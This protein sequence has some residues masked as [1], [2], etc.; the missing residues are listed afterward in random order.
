MTSVDAIADRLRR[1]GWSV[2]QAQDAAGWRVTAT[3]PRTLIEATAPTQL[4]AWRRAVEQAAAA[5]MFG[6]TEPL[7]RDAPA[8]AVVPRVSR[9]P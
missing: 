4:E 8:V 9:A 2:A 3:R 7:R 1:S 5:G 6:R